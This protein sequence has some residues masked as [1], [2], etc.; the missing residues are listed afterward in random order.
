MSSIHLRLL[1]T[2]VKNREDFVGVVGG[3]GERE[4]RGKMQESV[5]RKY[6]KTSLF[7]FWGEQ[8]ITLLH[9]KMDL[10]TA[11]SW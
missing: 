9:R 8:V 10:A 2:S 6:D 5:I 4:R 3:G 11:T 1:I 7:F